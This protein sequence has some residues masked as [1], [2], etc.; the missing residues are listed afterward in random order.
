MLAC[1]AREFRLSFHANTLTL[2]G[3]GHCHISFQS[4][5][6]PP[7]LS[8]VVWR[9]SSRS[10]SSKAS[11]YALQIEKTP[12]LSGLQATKSASFLRDGRIFK[13]SST[14]IGRNH[15]CNNCSF[16]EPTGVRKSATQ[17]YLQRPCLVIGFSPHGRGIHASRHTRM[18]APLPTRQIIPFLRSSRPYSI[19]L[20][21]EE[22]FPEKTVSVISPF[23]KYLALR[24]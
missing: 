21:V 17:R 14:S 22:A 1:V 9:P 13:M 2:G 11:R 7:G 23:G 24:T 18:L 19:A 12:C 20:H 10:C 4:E 15:L 6:S 16:H 8:L 3:T 5:L